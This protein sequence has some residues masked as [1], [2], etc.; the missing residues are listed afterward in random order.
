MSQAIIC[1]TPRVRNASQ[2]IRPFTL[3]LGAILAVTIIPLGLRHP[4]L[5]LLY[6]K[7]NSGDIVGN[8]LL[9]IPLGLVSPGR[10]RKAVLL[11]FGV[12]AGVELTQFIAPSRYPGLL[13]VVSNVLGAVLGYLMA[14]ALR[15]WGWDLRRLPVRTWTGWAALLAGGIFLAGLAPH[16]VPGDFS[17]W[18]SA[19]QLTFGDELAGGRRWQGEILEAQLLTGPVPPALIRTLAKEGVGSLSAHKSDLPNPPAFELAR[20][21]DTR[22][23]PQFLTHRESAALYYQAIRRNQLSALLWVRTADSRQ[24]RA[25]IISY[26]CVRSNNFWIGQQGN[27]I[28][29]QLRT[30]LFAAYESG[31]EFEVPASLEPGRD[32]LVAAVYDGRHISIYVD[33]RLAGQD[34]FGAKR[35]PFSVPALGLAYGVGAALTMAWIVL[36]PLRFRLLATVAVA[37]LIAALLI[38]RLPQAIYRGL[39]T[40]LLAAAAFGVWAGIWS[41]LL[42]TE[43]GSLRVHRTTRT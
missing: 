9:Y 8:T 27:N 17:N 14:I 16:E 38:P 18:D 19:C 6:V 7:W 15:R 34:D 2:V 21:V 39:S 23:D 20:P 31:Q 28:A 40:S 13:D 1:L 43:R 5:S 33:G 10:F 30:P 22:E 37:A 35:I 25:R 41:L 3:I 32:T 26:S 11:A 42:R 12:S 36:A 24:Q 4:S 29:I